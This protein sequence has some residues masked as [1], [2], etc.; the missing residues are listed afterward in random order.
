MVLGV[1]SGAFR[2]V[3]LEFMMSSWSGCL[4]MH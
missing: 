2:A 4:S 1:S 3:H